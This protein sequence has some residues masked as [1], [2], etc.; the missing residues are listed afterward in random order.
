MS[1]VLKD[2]AGPA[3]KIAKQA[4]AA[5][6]L[7]YEVHA[8]MEQTLAVILAQSMW[9]KVKVG[10]VLV[11]RRMAFGAVRLE[12]GGR[13]GSRSAASPEAGTLYNRPWQ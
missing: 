3:L 2:A 5:A 13:C 10:G 9:K 6:I 12:A 11:F 4:Q 7:G 1:R 8:I